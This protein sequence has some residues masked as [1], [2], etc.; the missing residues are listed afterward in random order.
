MIALPALK[1][2]WIR[3]FVYFKVKEVN[4]ALIFDATVRVLV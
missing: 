1:R 4:I 2:W 3:I